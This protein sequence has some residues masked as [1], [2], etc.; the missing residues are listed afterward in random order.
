MSSQGYRP[1]ALSSAELRKLVLD[2]IQEAPDKNRESFHALFDHP[3]R[4]L[5]ADDVIHGLESDWVVRQKKFN[6]DEW[7]WNY[8]I[9]TESID[10][11]PMEIVIAVDTC[12]REFVVITRW[13][14]D[15]P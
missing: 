7:Q 5:S 8:V 13:R 1:P 12:R 14:I 9:Q 6:E 11:E 15:E 2:A 10:G 3:E 4:G